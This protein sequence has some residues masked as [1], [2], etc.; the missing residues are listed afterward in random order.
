[1]NYTALI[2]GLFGLC[3]AYAL[4][5]FF[6]SRKKAVPKPVHAIFL[7][8]IIAYTIVILA[9]MPAAK[10]EYKPEGYEPLST[11]GLYLTTFVLVG[12]ITLLAVLFDKK[13]SLASPTKSLAFAGVSIALAFALSYVKLFSLGNG[14]SVTLASMLPIIIYS[15]IFGAKKGILCG[16]IYGAL[17]FIQSPI[18]YQAMQVLLDYPIAFGALGISG[19]AREFKCIKI[20]VVK[21]ILGALFAGIARY[22]SHFLSGYFIFGEAPGNAA[23]TYSLLYNLFVIVDVAICIGVGAIAF[24]YKGLPKLFDSLNPQE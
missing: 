2:L 12:V 14:G 6:I 23:L 9:I 1:M 22:I 15:Y 20:P 19:I 17:Q 21:F 8:A 5:S 4:T 3:L 7:T 18:P 10:D 16:V 24:S 13:K 11:W